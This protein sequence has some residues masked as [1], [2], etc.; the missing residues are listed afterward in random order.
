MTSGK[1]RLHIIDAKLTR[2][3]ETFGKMDPYVIINT[4]EQRI[5]TKTA[6]DQGKTPKWNECMDIDVKYIGDDLHLQVF[7]EDVTCSEIIGENRI[8]LS[9]F[10]VGNGIDEWFEIQHKGKKAGSVHMRAEWFPS[11]QP[12]AQVNPQARF[13]TPQVIFTNGQP[14]AHV[15]QPTA[16]P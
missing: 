2:D 7:D 10:C 8:K 3:T 15:V 5:R 12:L 1:L 13:A 6:Q 4:R 11:G 16:I 9:S 14:A